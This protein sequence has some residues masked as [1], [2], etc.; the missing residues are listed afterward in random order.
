M[1]AVMTLVA[2]GRER[3]A[4]DALSAADAAARAELGSWR[5]P[6]GRDA[7]AVT[8]TR[9]EQPGAEVPALLRILHF[10]V[11]AAPS[12]AGAASHGKSM[13]AHI[14][15]AACQA[16]A[17]VVAA[18]LMGCDASVRPDAAACHA[19]AIEAAGAGRLGGLRASLALSALARGLP[20]AA[21]AASSAVAAVS[22]PG[23]LGDV[24]SAFF[25]GSPAPGEALP[26]GPAERRALLLAAVSGGSE[27]CVLAVAGP[28]AAAGAAPPAPG[29]MAL[30]LRRQ[31]TDDDE[32]AERAAWDND[33]DDGS[34]AT[35]ARRRG[36]AGKL[37]DKLAAGTAAG[38]GT[39]DGDD[40]DDDDIRLRSEGWCL[41]LAAARDKP[42]LVATLCRLGCRVDAALPADE[43]AAVG[44]PE[45]CTALGVACALGRTDCVEALLD[46]GADA[47]CSVPL[48][49]RGRVGCAAVLVEA[50][51]RSGAFPGRAAGAAASAAAPA[52]LLVSSSED[53]AVRDVAEGTGEAAVSR[54]AR[55]RCG[56]DASGD[57]GWS[58]LHCAAVS[59]DTELVAAMAGRE[60][61]H[62]Q[63][64]LSARDSGGMTPLLLA[65]DRTLVGRAGRRLRLRRG[66]RGGGGDAGRGGGKAGGA[67]PSLAAVI[68]A[69]VDLARAAGCAAEAAG[70]T[71][72]AGGPAAIGLA[73]RRGDG[74]ALE[75]LLAVSPSALPFGGG[76][77][78]AAPE[79]AAGRAEPLLV[80]AASCPSPRLASS[81]VQALLARLM[82]A[83]GAA[84][85]G[86][87]GSE[88]AAAR[89][90]V[91]AVLDAR[92]VSP[93]GSRNAVAAAA[94]AGHHDV[95]MLLRRAGAALPPGHAAWLGGHGSAPE[96]SPGGEAVLLAVA[97]APER[98]RAPTLEALLA[99]APPVARPCLRP[100]APLSLLRCLLDPA[101]VLPP[102]VRHDAEW[103]PSRCPSAW[104]GRWLDAC[105]KS[106]DV[107]TTAA[108]LGRLEAEA[109]ALP[110]EA[111][112]AMREAVSSGRAAGEA[113]SGLEAPASAAS[114]SSSSSPAAADPAPATAPAPAALPAYQRGWCSASLV[115][116]SDALHTAAAGGK[117][118]FAKA[119]LEAGADPDGPRPG[120]R[121]LCAAA[122]LG[123]DGR[124]VVSLLLARGASPHPDGATLHSSPLVCAVE[125]GS[126]AAVR[127]IIAAGA[128]VSVDTSDGRTPAFVAMERGDVDV[129][130]ALAAAPDAE[131][132]SSAMFVWSDR[133]ENLVHAA[134]RGGSADCVAAA[135]NTGADVDHVDAQGATPLFRAAE[136][137]SSE[138]MLM[139]LRAGADPA[140][141]ISSALR[142]RGIQAFDGAD[143]AGGAGGAAA[144]GSVA[145]STRLLLGRAVRLLEQ[146]ATG[147]RARSGPSGDAGTTPGVAPASASSSSSAGGLAGESGAGDDG[148]EGTAMDLSDLA[149]ALASVVQTA[150]GSAR[151]PPRGSGQA[152]ASDDDGDSSG[153]S[154]HEEGGGV[155]AMLRALVPGSGNGQGMRRAKRRHE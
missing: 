50:L 124:A 72:G 20:G 87:E 47:G 116:G 33:S 155:E 143:H 101:L 44:V 65:A 107:A 92:A 35:G 45:G 58:A 62:L 121:P 139:L 28:R 71:L 12:L 129:L 134:V 46:A 63:R 146:E 66:G 7:L 91:E 90:N 29:G 38:G 25:D 98:R 37:G 14:C 125:G 59:G 137:A 27:Q 85:C 51:V 93:R 30:Q 135:L 43:A 82:A 4:A 144:A 149:A 39:D 17:P 111:W 78:A 60:A 75:R 68:G 53:A 1:A 117:E 73:A 150:S 6:D 94:A 108:I 103:H 153:S 142:Q 24:L 16:A 64:A 36:D 122:R 110:A 42:H 89:A 145:R 147:K 138:C 136:H 83:T 49:G 57:P 15:G 10:V 141:V 131:T 21:S 99:P 105:A 133:R 151:P 113:G 80:S 77:E 2:S 55:A 32:E 26:A 112:E 5:A 114:S 13:L 100:S 84:A 104:G 152:A 95:I 132:E 115:R 127:D 48:P 106:G 18:T 3:E 74:A 52:P 9:A 70:T 123:A 23:P 56:V 96:A 81:M 8:M 79:P 54:L 41:H 102:P 154:D 109:V 119:L 88:A 128:M 19:L 76:A 118:G 31:R 148:D 140:K 97:S 86:A 40:D 69:L 22:P 11:A 120:L 34:G 61:R 126:A 67:G 130:Y